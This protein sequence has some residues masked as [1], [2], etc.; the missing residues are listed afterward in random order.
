ME[1]LA[2][3]ERGQ[4]PLWMPVALGVGIAAWFLL[5]GQGAWAAFLLLALSI[6]FAGAVLPWGTRTARA[7]TMA[8]MLAMLGCALVWWRAERVA[9]PVLARP[10]VVAFEGVVERVEP[11]PAREAV[12]LTL[13]PDITAGLPPRIRVNLSEKDTPAGVVPGA[14]IALRARLMP[15]PTAAVPGAYDFAR[16][17]WFQGLGATGRGFA[18]VRVVAA[19]DPGNA[20]L[21]DRLT[22]H[23]LSRVEGSTGGIAAAFVTGDRGAITEADA[24][25]MRR[26][27]LAHLLS[28]SGLHVTAVVVATM[29]LV[30]KL[31]A[32]FPPLAL[33]VRLPV[34]AAGAGACAALFYTWLSGADVPTVR[35]CIAALLVLA[36]LSLGR[37]AITLRMIATGAL[38]VLL[39]LPESLAGP[40]FQLSFAA[41]TAI[42]ALHEHPG[43]RGWFLKREE[44]IG[45]RLLRELGSLLLTGVAVEAALMP[46]GLY[47]FHTAGLYGALANIVAIPLTTFVT[48]PLEALALLL[49][50]VG[51]GGPAWWAVERSLALLLWIAHR[52]TSAP[53]SVAALP[54]MPDGAFALMVAGGLWIALWR[55]RWRRWGVV[56]LIAGA[57][58]AL[59]TPAPDLL[60]TGDGRHLALATDDGGMAILRDRAGD[61]VRSTLG[62]GGGVIGELPP[63]SE[64]PGARCS[65]DLCIARRRAGG[66]VWTILATR[67][68]YAVPWAELVAAC[69]R[70]DIV[71]SERRL[72]DKC[73]PRWLKLD[74]AVLA[75]TGGV[76]VTLSTGR[77]TT[78]R[79]GGR[80]P[81]EVPQTIAPPRAPYR[82]RR[83]GRNGGVSEARR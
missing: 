36:A 50:P 46:I 33:R 38:L 47:H 53:G 20:A 4:L 71:V 8:G 59:A 44:A 55:T 28:I 51:L 73:I 64:Q 62:E 13:R 63:L 22:D 69:A 12:R 45:W 65:P 9:A 41:V 35:S 75:R 60:V 23:I 61:Y 43:V 16:A 17:A 10:V 18:P 76:A 77:V 81:W 40:S 29:T 57:V 54:A 72:P 11:L 48:M 15:P 14:R 24:E 82:E 79:R 3:A 58:W 5:P 6:A 80:H 21:R 37:E 68:G 27:G 2:E 7:V 30:L 83:N 39:V 34:V 1:A 42:V 70:A 66:R 74:R 26:S 31:L 19:G 56:P 49:D 52:V 67:S 25:A 32:L 78:V